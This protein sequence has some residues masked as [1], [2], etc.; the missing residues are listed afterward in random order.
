M[1]NCKVIENVQ[2]F[3]DVYINCYYSSL[4]PVINKFG[5]NILPFLLNN[6][7]YI[8][9]DKDMKKIIAEDSNIVSEEK[10]FSEQGLLIKKDAIGNDTVLDDI[11][12]SIKK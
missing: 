4:L 8:K 11:R 2:P 7:V 5:K 12:S 10:L 3:N 6:F 1:E 9:Y